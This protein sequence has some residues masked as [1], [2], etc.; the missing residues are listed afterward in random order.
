MSMCFDHIGIVV[1][2]LKVGRDYMSSWIG[3]VEWTEEFE[4][5][6]IKVFVQFGRDSSGICYELVAPLGEG[7]PVAKALSDR[8]N[9]LNHVAYVV[10][11][12]NT[13]ASRLRTLGAV[14]TGEAQP[15]KA[16][17]GRNIQFF[18]TPLRFLIELIEA[19]D[20]QHTYK[21]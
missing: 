8:I 6:G 14:P 16:Y 21:T 7:S 19:P 12:L 2:T 18:Y 1:P 9:I 20:H 11:D 17:G 13:E 10:S 15:A 4:D 5:Q 3:I